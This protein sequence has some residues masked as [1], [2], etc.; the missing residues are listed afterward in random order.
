[1][2]RPASL[3]LSPFVLVVLIAV[4]IAPAFAARSVFDRELDNEIARLV[5]CPTAPDALL[6][7]YAING[8]RWSA[9]QDGRVR[10]TNAWVLR[11]P[12]AS[13]VLKAQAL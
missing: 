9:A 8:L 4:S 5:E 13:P 7:L 10:A 11:Q 6:R 2:K 3:G 1:M 12:E